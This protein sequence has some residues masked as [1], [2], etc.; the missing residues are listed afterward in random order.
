MIVSEF[1]FT[2]PSTDAEIFIPLEEAR[3]LNPVT[4]ISLLMIITTIHAG[5]RFNSTKHISTE[6]MSNLSARGSRSFPNTVICFF[7]RA[8][9][10][11]KESV[12]AARTNM[13]KVVNSFPSYRI[14]RIRTMTGTDRILMNVRVLGKLIEL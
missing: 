9:Y 2:L 1:I 14:K 6:T 7:L 11:S 10:P 13:I 5:T 3:A 8:R 4:A 12:K